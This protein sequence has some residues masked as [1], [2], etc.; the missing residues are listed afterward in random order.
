MVEPGKGVLNFLRKL[1]SNCVLKRYDMTTYDDDKI[2]ALITTVIDVLT[3]DG[4]HHKQWALE[5]VLRTLAPDK[6]HE[7]KEEYEWEDGIAP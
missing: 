3:Y 4:G 7:Y 5:V 1:L 6:F 2:K